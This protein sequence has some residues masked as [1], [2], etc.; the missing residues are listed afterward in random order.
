MMRPIYLWFALLVVSGMALCGCAKVHRT[1]WRGAKSRWPAT[2]KPDPQMESHAR[3]ADGVIHEMKGELEAAMDSFTEAAAKDPDDEDLA[4]DVT[5]RFFQYKHPE[6]AVAVLTNAVARPHASGELFARLGFIYAQLGKPDLALA[7]NQKAV[8]KDPGLLGAQRSLYFGYLQ[9]KQEAEALKVLDNA[10]R[11]P[12]ANAEYLIGV[13]ELYSNFGILVPAQRT[14]ANAR[15]RE[16]LARAAG[17]NPTN[18][19]TRLK[20]ADGFSLLGE[21]AN[22]IEGYVAL[23][24]TLRDNP[25]LRNAVRAKL[26]ELHFRNRD[27]PRATEQFDAILRDDPANVQANFV[28]G[29][30]AFDDKRMNQAAD[31]FSRTILLNPGFEQAYY[32]LVSA[33]LNLDRAGEAL[34]TLEKARRRFQPNFL[35]EY[36][37]GVTYAQRKDYAEAIKY[38]TAAETVARA[39]ETNRL[40]HS[41]YYQLGVACE[42]SGDF[43][44]AVGH[45]E[46]CLALSPDYA[47]AQNYL[48]YMWVERG[49]NLDRAREL[50]DKAVKTEPDN[51]A[52]LDSLGWVLFKLGKPRE[53]LDPMLRAL[54]SSEKPDPTLYDHLGDIHA[55]LGEPDKAREAWRK[56]LELEPSD[57]IRKKLDSGAPK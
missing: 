25:P 9:N 36:L 50:I 23:I 28:L 38:Y 16:L 39:T 5:R 22:A 49:V 18:T 46:K 32:D 13:A 47:E 14:N 55:A 21:S 20:L 26:G 31:Y 48:G 11:T 45:F 53:A 6:R 41:F 1:G 2:A 40:T 52:F 44:T 15:A 17:L 8:R 35:I 33:Q 42:R 12:G 3:Y 37:T 43:P 34:A 10:T 24:E 51:A 29:S 4:Q 54:K 7:A 27:R 57:A 30:L 19:T 56:S